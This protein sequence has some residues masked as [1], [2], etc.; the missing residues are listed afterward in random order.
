MISKILGETK[1]MTQ[2]LNK[3][4]GDHIQIIVVENKTNHLVEV[5]ETFAFGGTWKDHFK[6]LKKGELCMVGTECT[7]TQ[8]SNYGVISYLVPGIAYVGLFW[9]K[10]KN[11][12]YDDFLMYHFDGT[13]QGMDSWSKNTQH[14]SQSNAGKQ[15]M[16]QSTHNTIVKTING[17]KFTIAAGDKPFKLTIG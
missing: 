9:Y 8:L 6:N 4:G 14:H 5:N 1:A 10:S 17:V 16:T 3:L 13:K 7:A 15:S 2:V 12:F 11:P